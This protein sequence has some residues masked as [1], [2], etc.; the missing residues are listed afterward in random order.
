[1]YIERNI[2]R[3]TICFRRWNVFL[4]NLKNEWNEVYCI[5]KHFVNFV[6]CKIPLRE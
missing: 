1:M 3:R 6:N 4:L 5:I 2:L